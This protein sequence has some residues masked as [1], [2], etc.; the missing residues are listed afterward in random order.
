[1]MP[2]HFHGLLQLGNEDLSKTISHLKGLTSKRVNESLAATGNVWQPSFY[3]RALRAE[4]DRRNIA[5]YIAANPLRAG[6]VKDIRYYS[7][8]NS[9]YL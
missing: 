9:I 1:M 8:W 5:R 7:Y 3:D 4:E 2:D 6:L